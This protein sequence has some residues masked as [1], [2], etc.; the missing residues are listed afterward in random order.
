MRKLEDKFPA[1][2]DVFLNV[3]RVPKVSEDELRKAPA[4]DYHYKLLCWGADWVSL[5]AMGQAHDVAL[6]KHTRG[7]KEFWVIEALGVMEHE[8]GKGIGRYMIEEIGERARA[9]NLPLMVY[10]DRDAVSFY[11]RCGFRILDTFAYHG[12]EERPDAIMRLV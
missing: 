1:W 8:R 3:P 12:D 5:F 4:N 9:E 2:E 10:A 11:I 7:I 6:V